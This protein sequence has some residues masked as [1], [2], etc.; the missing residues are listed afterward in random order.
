MSEELHVNPE[1]PTDIPYRRVLDHGFVALVDVMGEDSS[2]VQAARVSYG[3]GTK[4]MRSDKALISYLIRHRHTTPLEMVEFKFIIR[5]PVFVA[6]QV[7]RHRTASINEYSARYS[8]VPDRFWAPSLGA[9]AD[10]DAVN[11]Q[12]R[13]DALLDLVE[14][15]PDPAGDAVAC[16]YRE[17]ETAVLV[18]PDGTGISRAA[19][20][21]DAHRIEF[22]PRFS[23]NAD[24]AGMLPTE[25]YLWWAERLLDFFPERKEKMA[26]IRARYQEHNERSYA[27][28]QNFLREG[29]A[30]EIARSVLPLTM[31]TEWYWK[32]DL[33]NLF[34]FLRLRMDPHAQLEVRAFAEAIGTF[35]KEHMPHAWD[36][37]AND[38]LDGVFLCRDEKEVLRPLDDEAQR[39]VLQG[40]YERGY[41]RRRLKE[42][43]RKLAIDERIVD[44]LWP[45]KGDGA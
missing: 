31:Y 17:D 42:T 15:L 28:Y 37:F 14:A 40:L 8:E 6:R 22:A 10:Q 24:D 1:F 44:E 26:S 20:L 2:I 3:K 33:H 16:A 45:P 11:R 7:V 38:G 23:G 39:E 41:R 12:G 5:L 43:C 19:L 13:A 36:S 34:H 32:M 30:R 21:E 9:I 27:L 18:A 35:V 4:T 25:N 29:V